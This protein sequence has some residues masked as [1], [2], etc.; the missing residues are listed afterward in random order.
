MIKIIALDL[1]GT[2]TN[3][4]KVIT[5][6]TIEALFSAQR[7]GVTLCLASGRPPYGMR[8][9]ADQL[10]LKDY[11][12]LLLCYNGGYVEDCAEGT[13]LVEKKLPSES[14][15]HLVRMQQETGFC[16]MTYYGSYIYT[17]HADN[18]YVLVS[19]RNNNMQVVEVEDFVAWS[20]GKSLNKCLMVGNPKRMP[21]VEK[22]LQEEFSHGDTPLSICHSTPY[23][24]E[25]L[26]VGIDKGPGLQ[27]LAERLGITM[28]EVMS[29]GDSYND[30]QML[31]MS[32]IGV[33]MA[34]AEDAVKAVADYVTA[35]NNE[36]G[37]A[38]AIEKIVL[39]HY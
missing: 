38:Q 27:A 22:L 39:N 36:D 3:D 10:H 8:H 24:I 7:A 30:I 33:A 20:Q 25:C 18:Q 17:E 9:L 1:D 6:R 32:G 19:S 37:V 15:E 26:P 16:L 35:S 28:Q 14:I 29:F 13:V 4:A 5:P 11:H 21:I 34:N 2:L 31:Q 12:G 23:F